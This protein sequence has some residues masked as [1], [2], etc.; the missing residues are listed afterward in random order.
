MRTLNAGALA[1]LARIEAGETIPMVQLVELVLDTPQRYT[2]AGH[3]LAW[4]AYTWTSVGLLIE[5][6]QDEAGEI[7][8]LRLVFPGVTEAQLGL[9]LTTASEGKT[10]R[11]YDALLDP[12]TGVVED[13]VLSWAGT[14][15]VPTIEDGQV[16][17]IEIVAEHR[18]LAA[19]R[20]KP[21]RYSNDE[22]RRLFPGDTSLDFDPATDAAPLAWPAA[23][24]FMQ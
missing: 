23:S 3:D 20:S 6:V 24:F 9:A 8:E 4:N 11:I 15:N 19:L 10:V 21:S 12:A 18:G 5:P 22:Q 16:A 13:A 2:N 14:L 1:L 17:S 7:Q